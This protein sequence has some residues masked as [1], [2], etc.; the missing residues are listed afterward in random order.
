MQAAQQV[1]PTTISP[2]TEI[3]KI[4]TMAATSRPTSKPSFVT[5]SRLGPTQQAQNQLLAAISSGDY[6]PG[7]LLPSER[8]LCEM[9][10]VSRV[11][12]REALA[13][14]AATGLI[15]IQQGKGAFVRP[16]VADEY[17]GPFGLYIEMHRDE[18]SE[19]L[20]VRGA[21]DGLAASE[22]AVHAS[23]KARASLTRAHDDFKAAVLASATPQ[24]LTA[25]D[26]KFHEAIASSG[27]GTLLPG[28]L[29]E[30][31]NLLVESRH[32]LFA[33]EGQPKRSVADHAVILQA[34]LDGD[35]AKAQLC[36]TV[37]VEK[38]WSWVEEF[39]SSKLG[40]S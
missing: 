11:S 7:T 6:P 20:R 30:L 26:V 12:I 37:H 38:M 1:R 22:A 25:L 15:D 36:A 2:D 39:H 9:F 23:A 18:L 8:V 24:A 33:R 31:N 14:L 4:T 29:K 40:A 17:A 19:L 16:R 28:L 10:G 27:R 34:I 21:L 3:G 35:S 32:I 13:G 5:V